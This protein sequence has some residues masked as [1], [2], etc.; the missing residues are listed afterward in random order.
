MAEEWVKSAR[1]EA[2]A[3]FDARFEVEVELGALKEN[4]SK[5]AEQLKE[6]LRAKDSAKAGLMTTEKQFENIRKQLHYTEI[7]LATKKQLVMELREELRKAREAA[8]LL[9][10]VAKAEK[11]TAY[12][13]RIEE[14]QARL[15][16]EFSVV[17]RDYCDIAWGKALDVVRVPADSGLK[18]PKSIYYDPEIRKLSDPNSSH[19]KQVTQVSQLPKVDQVPPTPLE[20]PKD[21]HQD[22]GKGKEVNTF[23]GKDKGQDKKKNSSNPTEKASDTAVSQPDQAA[24]PGVPKTKA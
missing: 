12:T 19:P 16:A 3:A 24:D 4:H 23:K 5:M 1:R 13:L 10:E 14:T 8:Q 18:R 6:T 20:V 7:N 2:R 15:T 21:S 22:A 17:A 11:Q 9:K